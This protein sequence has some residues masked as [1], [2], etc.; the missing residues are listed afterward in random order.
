[1][2][3]ACATAVNAQPKAPEPVFTRADIA[4]RWW[5]ARDVMAVE[6]YAQWNKIPLSDRQ[7]ADNVSCDPIIY[8]LPT[9]RVT[10]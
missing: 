5:I 10:R 4:T 3:L 7:I 8:W 1:M 9:S 6:Y 2:V